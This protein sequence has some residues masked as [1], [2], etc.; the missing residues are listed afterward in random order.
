[1]AVGLACGAAFDRWAG[2]HL[3]P[4]RLR[5]LLRRRPLAGTRPTMQFTFSGMG[6]IAKSSG[7]VLPA[8]I[9]YAEDLMHRLGF[10]AGDRRQAIAWFEQGKNPACPFQEIADACAEEICEEPVLAEM[11]LECLCR[12]ALIADTPTSRETLYALAGLVGVEAGA[13]EAACSEVADLIS[14][15]P[16]ALAEAYEALNVAPGATEDEINTAYR[17]LIAQ[18]H[19][20]RLGPAA[21]PRQ[22]EH[23]TRRVAEIAEAMALI[24]A[25]R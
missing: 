18:H 25:S 9:D 8:H 12:I 21:T 16:P 24:R 5:R 13:C 11:M 7:S 10:T 6:R 4:A 20:D 22:V 17:R 2:R 14:E 23:A 19:P 15:P 1:V 3:H